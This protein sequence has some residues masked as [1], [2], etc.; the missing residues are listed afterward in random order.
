MKK[1]FSIIF[2][3]FFPIQGTYLSFETFINRYS[4]PFTIL[5][6]N[7]INQSA[8]NL[9]VSHASFNFSVIVYE[10]LKKALRNEPPTNSQ[11][12]FLK[13]KIDKISLKTLTECEY[14]D[15]SIISRQEAKLLSPDTI[16]MLHLLGSY[17]F[18]IDD[19]RNGNLFGTLYTGDRNELT[20]RNFLWPYTNEKDVK[21]H[22]IQS[23]FTEKDLI[24]TDKNNGNSVKSTWLPGINFIT[25]LALKGQTSDNKKL[26]SSLEDMK[27]IPHSEW[28]PH[29]M[30]IQG[31]T[32]EMIDLVDC[33][34]RAHPRL[35]TKD[36]IIKME[37]LLKEWSK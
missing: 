31:A 33:C 1:K 26:R 13:K 19:E 20:R 34:H 21:T 11:I 10:S 30:V 15:I 27:S 29:N 24:K 3:I 22:T 9:L 14:F 18:V 17:L 7:E 6:L 23:S 36:E 25:F 16:Q 2:L 37:I 32:L 35:P 8:L 4:R 28:G 5:F 12:I